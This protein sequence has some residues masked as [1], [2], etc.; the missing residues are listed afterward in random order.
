M[1]CVSPYSLKSLY[2]NS[3]FSGVP[4]ALPTY[5]FSHPLF[6]SVQIFRFW[7]V[8][9]CSLLGCIYFM[10]FPPL[11]CMIILPFYLSI[12]HH[13][14]RHLKLNYNLLLI[15]P[16]PFTGDVCSNYVL[17]AGIFV[18]LLLLHIKPPCSGKNRH[19]LIP[20]KSLVESCMLGT[21]KQLRGNV[22]SI[23]I[24]PTYFHES[25]YNL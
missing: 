7:K 24:P 12:I 20:D 13:F 3:E 5:L 16:F 23:L 2:L 1:Q 14:H 9:I 18:C 10:L 11:P 21:Q 25:G 15:R 17:E 4:R 6:T 8:C 22:T 19:L